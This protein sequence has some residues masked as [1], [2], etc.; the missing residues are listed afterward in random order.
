MAGAAPD[1]PELAFLVVAPD[2]FRAAIDGFA[3]DGAGGLAH[4]LVAGGEDDLVGWELGAV[5]EGEGVCV[6]GGDF[7]ALFDLDF[8]VGD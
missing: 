1:G 8:P 4:V 2:V 5:G 7:L 3:E 6:H